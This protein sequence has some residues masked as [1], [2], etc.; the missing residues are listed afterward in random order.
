MTNIAFVFPGQGSQYV[1]MGRDLYEN[2]NEV[3]EVIDLASKVLGY[4]VSRLCFY[5]PKEELDKTEKTQPC[6]LTVSI[7][8]NNVLLSKGIK[9]S[10]VAGHSLGE[11]S[12]IVSA[13]AID[14]E[15]A[16]R[17][18]EQRG[19]LMQELVPEGKGLMAAIIG[20]DKREIQDICNSLKS[21]YAEG[22]NYNSPNQIVVA[23]ERLA[24]LEVLEKA[25]ERGAKKAV[26]LSVS[27]PSHCRLMEP[28]SEKLKRILEGIDIKDAN[29]P[30]VNNVEARFI[31]K[32]E[33]IKLSLIKQ[34]SSPLLWEDSIKNMI[35]S[36][37]NTFVEVGPGKVLSNLIKR[38]DTGVKVL[39]VEDTKTLQD[40]LNE[41]G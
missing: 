4:D 22:A 18:T 1:G 31:T 38:I 23:G 10:L 33:D 35:S 8:I 11:Y 21:G 28:V 41:L 17:L 30:I 5:G 32:K 7:S 24:V 29:L 9:P 15:D 2:Y 3:R 16:V 13:G 27:V 20:L 36:G 25:K 19:R 12:A 14:F 40:I 37:I 6:I 26:I 34:L 39:N